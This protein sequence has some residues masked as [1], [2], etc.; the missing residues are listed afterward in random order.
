VLGAATGGIILAYELGKQLKTKGIF[1]ERVNGELE[2]RRGF[3]MGKDQRILLVDDVVTTGGSV[4]ELIS[5]TQST[6]ANITGI[7]VMFDRTNG[8]IDFGHPFFAIHS[9][10]I[11]SWEEGGCPQCMQQIPITKRGS[12]GK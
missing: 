7:A 12:T 11:E 9:E 3:S 2:F 10:K 8:E 1:A 4:F 6:G 5:L